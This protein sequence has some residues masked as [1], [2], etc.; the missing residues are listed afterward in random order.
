[1][2]GESAENRKKVDQ[3]LKQVQHAIAVR[4]WSFCHPEPGPE[5]ASGSKD[6]GI[7]IL[8]PCPAPN[9]AQN[10][11]RYPHEWLN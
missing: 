5:L 8:R 3:M 4:F 6:F 2:K 11:R 9:F 1:M 10:T 7:S